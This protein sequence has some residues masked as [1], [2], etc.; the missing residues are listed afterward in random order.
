M[1]LKAKSI[2]PQVSSNPVRER[3]HLGSCICSLTE[4]N[5]MAQKIENPY[6]KVT[7][8]L[9]ALSP[10]ELLKL[11]DEISTLIKLYASGGV[12][13]GWGHFELKMI[14]KRVRQR[15]EDGKPMNDPVTGEPLWE[16]KHFGPYL[17]LKR[18][19]V[20]ANGKRRLRHAAYYGKAGAALMELG[21]GKELLEAHNTG[22][23]AAGE[24]L[25]SQHLENELPRRWHTS[26]YPTDRPVHPYD[27]ER[28]TLASLDDNPIFKH[29]ERVNPVEAQE[30]ERK[31]RDYESDLRAWQ[32]ARERHFEWTTPMTV[33]TQRRKNRVFKQGAHPKR[34]VY[35][36][37][38]KNR[39]ES[40][41][42]KRGNNN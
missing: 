6:E 33:I 36:R 4:I 19:G 10:D 14:K 9:G 20:D 24:D 32:Y 34:I 18:W 3:V 39:S 38:N 8:L 7:G 40:G 23:E 42:G 16:I 2:F 1:S 35:V 21:L 28:I 25:I 11:R 17:Y 29:F 41:S 15:D 27:D 5:L 30:M 22:G 37:K 12:L 26:K 31:I 13:A